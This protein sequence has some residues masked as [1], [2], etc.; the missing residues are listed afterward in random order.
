M[1]TSSQ[2]LNN[3]SSI[4]RILHCDQKQLKV[5]LTHQPFSEPAD[6]TKWY[7]H[8]IS[9]SSANHATLGWT[10][11]IHQFFPID[12]RILG[13]HLRHQLLGVKQ[14]G[15]RM[16]NKR[17]VGWKMGSHGVKDALGQ[18]IKVQIVYIAGT[19]LRWLW[20]CAWS[21]SFFG[22]CWEAN[23]ALGK[24]EKLTNGTTRKSQVKKIHS[25]KHQCQ[26]NLRKHRCCI[27]QIDKNPFCGLPTFWWRPWFVIRK[28]DSNW[29]TCWDIVGKFLYETSIQ[30]EAFSPHESP[31]HVPP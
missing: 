22:T 13:I 10:K 4:L 29:S 17:L 15:D 1:S 27:G 19:F 5:H 24:M 25:K 28:S 14:A 6:V 3:S 12:A 20:D 16:H 7:S 26:D 30:H 21:S 9:I 31:A 8:D 23:V 2:W 11:G 18:Q